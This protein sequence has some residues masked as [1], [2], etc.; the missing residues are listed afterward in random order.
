MVWFFRILALLC[1][2]AAADAV[3]ATV[4]GAP[5][6]IACTA[7]AF[8]LSALGTKALWTRPQLAAALAWMCLTIAFAGA[9]VF[10]GGVDAPGAPAFTGL[11]AGDS[12]ALVLAVG[13]ALGAIAGVC[14]IRNAIVRAVIVLAALY[15]IVPTAAAIGH[16]GLRAALTSSPL[17]PSRG[18]YAGAEIVLPLGALCAIALALAYLV[19]KRGARS[20]IAFMTAVALLAAANLGAYTAGT[21]QLP[22][23]AAFERPQLGSVTG[24]L[25]A[26]TESSGAASAHLA[27]AMQTMAPQDYILSAREQQLPT[28]DAAFAY[29]R[30]NIR[31]ESYSGILRG[32]Q[33]TFHARAGNAPDRAMLLAAILETNKIPVRL[34]TGHLPA[35]QAERLFERI[36]EAAPAGGASPAPT[37]AGASAL[38]DRLLARAHRNYDAILAALGN[39]VPQITTDSHDDLIK[40]IE[41]HAWVQAQVNGQWVDLDP[42]FPDSTVGHAYATAEQTY[43]GPPPPLLQQVTIRVTTETLQ[44]GALTKDVALETTVPAYKIIDSQVFLVHPQGGLQGVLGTKDRLAPVLDVDGTI[45]TGKPI[46]FDAGASPAAAAAAAAA[47]PGNQILGAFGTSASA[48]P[49]ASGPSFVAEW[50]EFEI[51]FPDG[52][53]DLTRRVLVDRAGTAWRHA[54]TLDPTRL[55][56]LARN[57]DGLI[58]PQTIYNIWFSAG[59]HDLL[60]FA[61]SA[62]ALENG[63]IPSNDPKAPTFEEQAWPFAMSDLG[64]FIASDHVLV[65]SLN[66]APGV[67]FYADSPRIFVWSLGPDPSGK[68]KSLLFE[69]DLRRDKLRGVAKDPSGAGIIAQHKLWFGALEG[70]LETELAART[71]LDPASLVS[72][73]SLTDAGSLVAI[74]PGSTASASDPETEARLQVALAGGDTLVVPKQ[75]LSGGVSGWWQISHDTGDVRPVLADDLDGLGIIGQGTGAGTPGYGNGVCTVLCDE[76]LNPI[77]YGK[78]PPP[79]SGGGGEIGEYAFTLYI[80]AAMVPIVKVVGG[81]IIATELTAIVYFATQ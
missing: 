14:A 12:A 52:H 37:P 59:K 4:H 51:D 65:P 8:I 35:D 6:A 61:N 20:A 69:S 64:W 66:D 73:S 53:K 23:I 50:L 39:S 5:L 21:V 28:V 15:V 72:T 74:G 79:K 10:A 77:G 56:D 49:S 54:A 27:E 26:E 29:V 71:N 38:K 78:K 40:E 33:G 46:D 31:F 7:I 81:A 24:P 45:T 75:V 19:K 42:S 57:A 11:S 36:F 41:Q 67:R 80:P 34:V 76:N 58:G 68:P 55:H 43:T 16:G 9:A 32:A 70:A 44:A 2:S 13:A 60:A 30:D 25:A 18:T 3:V 22:T 48:A 47:A 63:T 1:V 17:A 62:R